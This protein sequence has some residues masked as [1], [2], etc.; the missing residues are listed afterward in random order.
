[1]RS[2]SASRPARASATSA[3][4]SARTR[5][6]GRA[7]RRELRL[8][9]PLPEHRVPAAEPVRAALGS[10]RAQRLDLLPDPVAAL[11]CRLRR[12]RRQPPDEQLP[13]RQR[14]AGAWSVELRPAPP[15]EAAAPA[16]VRSLALRFFAGPTP[17][18]ALGRFTRATGRQPLPQG[19]VGLRALV[20]G[21][22]PRRSGRCGAS[23]GRC[24]R[25]RLAD[26]LHYLPCGDQRGV[27][28]EQ[29]ARTAAAHEQGLAITTYFN[30]MVCS[31][32]GAAYGP[33]AASRG[34]DPD[35][36]RRALP[37]SLRRQSDRRQHRRPVRLLRAARTRVYGER[38]QEAIGDGYDGWMEDFGE[39]TPLDSVSGA[40]VPGTAAHNRYPTSLPLRRLRGDPRRAAADHPL[41]AFRLDRRGALCAGRLGWRSDHRLGLRRARSA[42]HQ[43]I[44][45]GLSGVSIWGSDIGGFFSIARAC[46]P[47][48]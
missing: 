14:R 13:A 23:G 25:V 7:A 20:S 27:E 31:D 19:T 38:L 43:A 21:R 26:I 40:G 12:P 1:M 17:A 2:G 33:A 16:P 30:P 8:R 36:R 34:A 45:M 39:Y 11:E 41:S 22:Q 3:S 46:R 48:C 37:V 47:S 35:R 29:P 24:A 42:S 6:I 5:S 18:E 10:A 15:G 32:F 9:R 28:S 44:T 4:A